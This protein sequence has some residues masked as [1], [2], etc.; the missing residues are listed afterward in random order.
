MDILD[1][2]QIA[3]VINPDNTRVSYEENRHLFRKVA[4]DVFQLADSP[5]ESYWILETGDD[6]KEYLVAQYDEGV[7]SADL[8]VR[9]S[10]NWEAF[11]DKE[12]KNVTVFYKGVPIRRCASSEFG[13]NEADIHIFRQ[14][15]INGLTSDASLVTKMIE[16]M[17][18]EKRQAL[19]EQFPEL[20]K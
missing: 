1:F 2:E 17:P 8:E 7:E 3:R 18:E 5:I 13:F 14:A 16:S 15:L 6:G 11:S 12:A 10:V 20:S 9:G 19:Q 4:F